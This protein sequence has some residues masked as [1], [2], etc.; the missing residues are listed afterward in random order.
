[1]TKSI[2]KH[3]EASLSDFLLSETQLRWTERFIMLIYPTAHLMKFSHI[4]V[5]ANGW[6]EPGVGGARG[7]R[8]NEKLKTWTTLRTPT[9][10]CLDEWIVPLSLSFFS[11]KCL[12][13]GMLPSFM[14]I[15][16]FACQRGLRRRRKRGVEGTLNSISQ[17][18]TLPA[19]IDRQERT[20][21]REGERERDK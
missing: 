18:S 5:W 14:I 21:G 2:H 4:P 16:T 6:R 9:F 10:L 20:R 8:Q 15:K 1:M 3:P 13:F 11:I 19:L 7:G 17:P 12:P